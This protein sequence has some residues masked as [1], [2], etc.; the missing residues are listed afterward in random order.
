MFKEVFV[1]N[2]FFKFF[3]FF[4][5]NLKQMFLFLLLFYSVQLC[6]CSAFKFYCKA[7]VYMFGFK[8][9]NRKR[10][11]IEVIFSIWK[12]KKKKTKKNNNN[13][14]KIFQ[15]AQNP[16]INLKTKSKKKFLN[17][18]LQPT[19]KKKV[20]VLT[21]EPES[22]FE[23]SRSCFEYSFHYGWI[24]RYVNENGW[25]LVLEIFIQKSCNSK[26]KW[27][28]MW[29]RKKYWKSNQE[30]FSLT[31]LWPEKLFKILMRAWVFHK[32]RSI[33]NV[34]TSSFLEKKTEI[35]KNKKK[36]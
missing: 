32:T 17:S 11:Q 20:R 19:K 4:I 14:N 9:R 13:N 16:K 1:R 24:R 22:V 33:H 18:K 12:K 5:L 34:C 3:F 26:S 36:R 2:F 28:K 35:Q 29:K 10:A 8:V 25:I 27:K 7:S 6:I 30:L 23:F 21:K 31:F 15:N